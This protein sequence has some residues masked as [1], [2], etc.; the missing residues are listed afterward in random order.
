MH[1]PDTILATL[2]SS[3]FR[4]KFHIEGRDATY[5][6]ER[7]DDII[8]KHATRIVR[9]RLAPSHPI[10]DGRQTPLR[11][12]PVFVAQHAT[13]TC[14]RTCLRKWHGIEAG[15]DLTEEQVD[16]VVGILLAWIA[17]ERLPASQFKLDFGADGSSA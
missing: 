4:A 12:H 8:R 3:Q 10:N 17:R 2:S 14:C 6:A 16:Y 5:L 9:E 11:G 7:D 15:A 13:A 1:D